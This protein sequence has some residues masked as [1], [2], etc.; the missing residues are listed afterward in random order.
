MLNFVVRVL[1]LVTGE[2][3]FRDDQYHIAPLIFL[4]Q[5]FRCEATVPAAPSDAEVAARQHV[6][7]DTCGPNEVH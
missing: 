3:H 2:V 1:Q 6:T 7:F 5:R 4:L